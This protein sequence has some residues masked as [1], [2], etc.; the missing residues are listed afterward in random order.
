MVTISAA[1]DH[2]FCCGLL[3]TLY[4]QY[5]YDEYVRF[6]QLRTRLM[7]ATTH[8][9]YIDGTPLQITIDGASVHE[10][11]PDWIGATFS[12]LSHWFKRD[13]SLESADVHPCRFRTSVALHELVQG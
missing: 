4:Y 2:H 1:S 5:Q 7:I 3:T 12:Q 9:R 13:R 10:G 11:C 8:P 6:A